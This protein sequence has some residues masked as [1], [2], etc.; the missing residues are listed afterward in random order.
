MIL[1][2]RIYLIFN[3]V[4][5][6]VDSSGLSFIIN[7]LKQGSGKFRYKSRF[8]C[9][10]DKKK[11]RPHLVFM[12]YFFICVQVYHRPCPQAPPPEHGGIP[13]HGRGYA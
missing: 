12:V 4:H 5:F 3:L 13:V 8:I 11:S 1:M 2:N 9:Q 10:R 6:L 7:L